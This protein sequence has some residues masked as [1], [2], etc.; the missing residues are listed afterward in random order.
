MPHRGMRLRIALLSLVAVML[1]ALTGWLIWSYSANR[2]PT[3]ATLVWTASD[4]SPP[5]PATVHPYE[6]I[7]T[8]RVKV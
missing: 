5:Q 3:G 2:T 4:E 6:Q 7:P 8:R 1:V